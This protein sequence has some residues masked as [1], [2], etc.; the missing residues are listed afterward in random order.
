MTRFDGPTN[1]RLDRELLAA[2]EEGRV[3]Y[4]IYG[5]CGAWVSLGMYQRPERVLR[6]DCTTPYVVRPTGGRAVLHGHDVTVSLAAP[7][8]ALL[9]GNGRDMGAGRPVR[10]V[11]RRLVAPIVEGLCA[12]GLDARL[13]EQTGFA[14]K[15]GLSPDCFATAAD[16]DVVD[17]ATGRKLCGCALRLTERAALLQASIPLGVPLVPPESLFAGYATIVSTAH[18]A[19]GPSSEGLEHRLHE[20]LVRWSRNLP[21]AAQQPLT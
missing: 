14:A 2:A 8:A 19:M 11:Y 1:M 10:E 6:P 20:V 12:A 13:A 16:N 15:P 4:R 17:A 7:R 18:A 3:G 21:S 5:W 9:A